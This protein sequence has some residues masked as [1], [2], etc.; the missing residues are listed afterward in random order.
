MFLIVFYVNMQYKCWHFQL[1]TKT[2]AVC[3]ILFFYT[4]QKKS[5]RLG[6][7][8]ITHV[9]GTQI[10]N[11]NNVLML[12]TVMWNKYS[13]KHNALTDYPVKQNSG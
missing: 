12:I 10:V 1:F 11:F 2:L 7:N 4:M 3:S 13:A 6:T 5:S 8:W 9:I